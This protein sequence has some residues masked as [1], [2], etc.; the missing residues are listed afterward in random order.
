VQSC[1][2]PATNASSRTS[3][4]PTRYTRTATTTNTS[5]GPLLSSP[6]SPTCVPSVNASPLGAMC[7]SPW[8]VS[9]PSLYV[10]A[11][12]YS[13]FASPFGGPVRLFCQRSQAIDSSR[14]KVKGYVEY[15]SLPPSAFS[16]V[17]LC[18]A[19]SSLRPARLWPSMTITSLRSCR[20]NFILFYAESSQSEVINP[21]T[22][23]ILS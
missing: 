9:R 2:T 1:A 10:I 23:D 15:R 8:Q 11:R 16:P 3:G 21:H 7:S 20:P 6:A 13:H 5:D 17:V 4:L 19:F 12:P 14:C 18:L 22:L